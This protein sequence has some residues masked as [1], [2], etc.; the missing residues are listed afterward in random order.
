[1]E[2]LCIGT[3]WTYRRED[4]HSEDK[5]KNFLNGRFDYFSK[6]LQEYLRELEAKWKD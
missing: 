5:I 4:F 6:E 1:M 2:I 3:E